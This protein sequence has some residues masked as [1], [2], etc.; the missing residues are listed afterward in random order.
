M[1][2]ES[3]ETWRFIVRLNQTILP[4]AERLLIC[5]S[6]ALM[7]G[8]VDAKEYA[9]KRMVRGH[10]RNLDFLQ[11]PD[12]IFD[13]RKDIR[14]FKRLCHEY[15]V[16][17]RF[18]QDSAGMLSVVYDSR[19][20]N[21]LNA[22]LR[23]A[24]RSGIVTEKEMSRP[25][26]EATPL[27]A[28]QQYAQTEENTSEQSESGQDE[29]GHSGHGESSAGAPQIEQ[30]TKNK[31]VPI[32]S[33]W[34]EDSATQSVLEEVQ[35]TTAIKGDWVEDAARPDAYSLSFTDNSRAPF[36][37]WAYEDG[38]WEIE[39]SSGSVVLGEHGA[40]R[41]TVE[42]GIEAAMAIASMQITTLQRLSNTQQAASE[43]TVSAWKHSQSRPDALF[44]RFDDLDGNA[45]CAWANENGSWEIHHPDGSIASDLGELLKGTCA[46]MESAMTAAE[47]RISTMR[48]PDVR[49]H[50]ARIQNSWPTS[51]MN[52][53]TMTNELRKIEKQ[54]ST[55]GGRANRGQRLDRLAHE[56]TW[57]NGR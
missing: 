54:A 39:N 27:I 19:D 12:G 42:G 11:V 8:V 45:Y 53:T 48:D 44:K 37:A 57:A 34:G 51:T 41:G 28:N 9:A 32:E 6:R 13:D 56:H 4:R 25:I 20:A 55:Q 30:E 29:S 38:S 15:G 26:V 49:M 31:T 1:S 5:T 17:V 36:T 22:V 16:S 3:E 7:R 50:A 40:L 52:L 24:V 10:R 14:A 35:P 43:S 46:D 23:A 47:N 2:V 18:M 33:V 21:A